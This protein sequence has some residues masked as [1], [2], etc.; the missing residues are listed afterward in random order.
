MIVSIAP[1][2]IGTGTQAVDDLG[3]QRIAD[4]IRLGNRVIHPVGDDVVLAWDV[5]A[6]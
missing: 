5:A 2:V 3:T 1:T 4:G 6:P